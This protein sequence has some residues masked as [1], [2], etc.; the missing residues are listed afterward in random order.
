MVLS[1][2]QWGGMRA[3]AL[4]LV[5]ALLLSSVSVSNA[6]MVVATDDFSAAGSGTGW[7][8]GSSWNFGSNT[9]AETATYANQAMV[10]NKTST[11]YATR[12]LDS[13][14]NGDFFF[15][16]TMDTSSLSAN[17]N[18]FVTFWFD[19]AGGA[20]PGDSYMYAPTIGLK[21]D[22]GNGSMTDDFMVR[23]GVD[24]ST[25][26]YSDAF[27]LA[28]GNLFGII[29]KLSKSGANGS[30]F[31]TLELWVTDALGGFPDFNSL[32]AA[33]AVSTGNS[34]LLSSVQT[35]GV[36]SSGLTGGESVLLD[37]ITIATVPEPMTM[38]LWGIGG[39][40]GLAYSARRRRKAAGETA[41]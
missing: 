38:A 4:M 8:A 15:A 1:C 31:D 26:E 39:V 3:F 14:L 37:N 33:Q 18:D 7:A 16:F 24:G 10:V 2:F 17:P 35:V 25:T 41:A 29:G 21:V 28:D 22:G 40:A 32:G 36:R 6:A 27:T 9:A 23:F 30:S 12:D 34:F 13:S 19:S 5:P 11:S 20:Y